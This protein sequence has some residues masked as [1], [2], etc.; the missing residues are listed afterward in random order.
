M[1]RVKVSKGI[2]I[3]LVGSEDIE[4]KINKS[5]QGS[6]SCLSIDSGKTAELGFMPAPKRK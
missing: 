4:I 3:N 6:E 5:E 2:P 1:Q